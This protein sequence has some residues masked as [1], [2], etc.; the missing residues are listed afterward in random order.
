MQG[1]VSQENRAAL[2]R[3]SILLLAVGVGFAPLV[4]DFGLQAW[5]HPSAEI[6]LILLGGAIWLGWRGWRHVGPVGPTVGQR[7][8]APAV[9]ILAWL[10]LAAAAV[11]DSPNLGI[12]AL[13]IALAAWG[14]A[15]GGPQL[16]RA[17][18]PALGLLG[19]VIFVQMEMY[20]R[21]A[22]MLQ[23]RAAIGASALLDL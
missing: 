1:S 11:L 6:F 10:V 16:V 12:V 19:C 20:Q 2:G 22:V 15:L 17:W 9:A 21:L 13:V 7:R 14:L 8:Q 4:A 23:E 3:W 18:V 5:G